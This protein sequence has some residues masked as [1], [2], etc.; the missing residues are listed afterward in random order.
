MEAGLFTGRSAFVAALRDAI[1]TATAE[2]CRE[3]FWLDVN[4]VDWPLSD[5]EVLAALS[6]WAR[7]PHRLHLLALDFEA[8]RLRHPRFVAWRTAYGHC[9]QARAVD[10]ELAASFNSGGGPAAALLAAPWSL[11]LFE[12]QSWRGTV[13]LAAPDAL[14]TRERF[15][16]MAQRSCESFAATT[17]GL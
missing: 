12:T 13:S 5:A 3:M 17:L 1:V 8:L 16:A 10:P 2:G 7:P 4:F 9:V 11:R 15:D 14:R 6:A